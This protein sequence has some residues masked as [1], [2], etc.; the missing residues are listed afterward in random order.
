LD[1]GTYL[2]GRPFDL[3]LGGTGAA[4]GGDLSPPLRIRIIAS[5][6]GERLVELGFR[7]WI[8]LR[9]RR[10]SRKVF[11]RQHGVT[12]PH[13][14]IVTPSYTNTGYALGIAIGFKPK[15]PGTARLP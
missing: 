4:A 6:L 5:R 1:S 13:F 8:G 9:D 12:L 14:R 15:N 2:R 3:Y 11:C 7:F 10:P